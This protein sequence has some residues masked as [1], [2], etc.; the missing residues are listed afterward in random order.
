MKESNHLLVEL[1]TTHRGNKYGF[2]VER[3]M[4]KESLSLSCKWRMTT[5][6][7]KKHSKEYS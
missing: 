7:T 2:K 3:L 4:K 6:Q 1:T 5:I